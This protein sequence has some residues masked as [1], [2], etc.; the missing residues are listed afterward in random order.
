MNALIVERECQH[1]QEDDNAEE[2]HH[3]GKWFRH[4]SRPDA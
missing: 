3:I 4:C 2:H 1:T